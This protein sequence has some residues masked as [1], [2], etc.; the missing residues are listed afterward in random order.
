MMGLSKPA[1]TTLDGVLFVYALT[2]TKVAGIQFS[3]QTIFF[4]VIMAILSAKSDVHGL[5]EKAS[6][7]CLKLKRA[8]KLK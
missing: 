6:L 2:N 1:Q 3:R 7:R 4:R 8:E 5:K